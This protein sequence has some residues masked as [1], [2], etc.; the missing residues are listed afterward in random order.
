[1]FPDE[2]STFFC[3]YNH[4]RHASGYILEHFIRHSDIPFGC[5]DDIADQTPIV[6]GY[7][8][9]KLVKDHRLV[10]KSD[11]FVHA[12]ELFFIPAAV[13]VEIHPYLV[14]FLGK[15]LIIAVSKAVTGLVFRI[16]LYF[17]LINEATKPIL[18]V[19]A[20]HPAWHIRRE[21]NRRLCKVKFPA[22]KLPK[23]PA[24]EHQSVSKLEVVAFLS[25]NPYYFLP[26]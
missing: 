6:T 15:C 3:V 11:I 26:L 25:S 22:H 9:D 17:A 20:V 5:R 13:E 14:A 16:Y 23:V 4:N 10:N 7:T 19:I 2:L 24:G 12:L 21:D 1:M 18:R 8:L